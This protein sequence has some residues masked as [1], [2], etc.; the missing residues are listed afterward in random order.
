MICWIRILYTCPINYRSW[1]VL[2]NRKSVT[3]SDCLSIH[4]FSKSEDHW[5]WRMT[6]SFWGQK[7]CHCSRNV[8]FIGVTVTDR[9]VTPTLRCHY[10][11]TTRTCAPRLTL[12]FSRPTR[13]SRINPK[14]ASSYHVG[15]YQSFGHNFRN[16]TVH[17]SP[18]R[19][20]CVDVPHKLQE[21][22][23]YWF[24]ESE[25]QESQ[26]LPFFGELPRVTPF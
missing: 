2:R 5:N 22:G 4:I 15:T 10:T 13:S 25:L 1:A 17:C 9:A 19:G 16:F 8:T 14:R 3:V 6:R 12:C 7:N 20:V 26:F 11:Q 18:S 23:L 21:V 24:L